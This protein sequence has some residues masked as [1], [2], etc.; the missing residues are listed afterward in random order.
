MNRQSMLTK[1]V[2]YP[3]QSFDAALA[4][5]VNQQLVISSIAAVNGTVAKM[6]I[7][8]GYSL[9]NVDWQLIITAGGV[10]SDY[11]LVIQAGIATPIIGTTNGDSFVVGS[12]EQ[13]GLLSF[14]VNQA[15][16]GSPVYVY[17]YWNGS[18]YVPLQL[19]S[20]PSYASTGRQEILFTAPV[21]WASVSGYYNVRVTASTAPGTVVEI[22]TLKVINVLTYREGVSPKAELE[23]SFEEPK[24]LLLQGQAEIIPY[25]SFSSPSNSMEMS[26]QISP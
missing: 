12:K 16:T 20:T 23:L 8:I 26:Y 18:A 19:I 4:A 11:S 17:E 2:A 21:D 5:P 7:A 3:N 22:N 25:F 1:R 9:N 6:D 10:P 24:Q 15:S 14:N 13:F